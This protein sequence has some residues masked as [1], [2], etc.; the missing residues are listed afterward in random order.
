MSGTSIISPITAFCAN[1]TPS[2][3][4][5]LSL[6]RLFQFPRVSSITI[7]TFI[8]RTNISISYGLCIFFFFRAP[9]GEPSTHW[10]S[11]DCPASLLHY[12]LWGDF[13]WGAIRISSSN[14]PRVCRAVSPLITRDLSI[15]PGMYNRILFSVLS[16][17]LF[18]RSI[19]I[20]QRKMF[21]DFD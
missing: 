8:P 3:L 1:L 19:V 20:F 7:P 15:L 17:Q 5:N 14:V 9:S 6:T 13:V 4:L 12:P 2:M 21:R 16:Q 11:W 18:M 10:H